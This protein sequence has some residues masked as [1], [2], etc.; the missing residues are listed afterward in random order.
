MVSPSKPP[1]TSRA[2]QAGERPTSGPNTA[3]PVQPAT[4]KPAVVLET[5]EAFISC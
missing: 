5:G 2:I 1:P 3:S 4:A